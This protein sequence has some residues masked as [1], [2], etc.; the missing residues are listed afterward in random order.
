MQYR[1]HKDAA[2]MD[3]VKK[4][5]SIIHNIGLETDVTWVESGIKDAYS[6]HISISHTS[7]GANGKGTSKEYALASGYAE[8]IERIQNGILKT[9]IRYNRVANEIGFLYSPDEKICS[10]EDILLQN[11][12]FTR[13]F[14]SFFHMN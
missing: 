13:F 11:D 4:I 1:K 3:T 6:N 12:A 10:V 14:F 7:F 2:P 9:A 8:L 5:Q